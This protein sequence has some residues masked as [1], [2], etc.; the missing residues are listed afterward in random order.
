MSTERNVL[1]ARLPTEVDRAGTYGVSRTTVTRAIAKLQS[2]GP[3][4]SRQGDGT[5]VENTIP[6]A[7]ALFVSAVLAAPPRLR[8]LLEL[9]RL[10]EKEIGRLAVERAGVRRGVRRVSPHP[11]R[12]LR[13]SD[14]VEVYRRAQ[15]LLKQQMLL[16]SRRTGA[17]ER[18]IAAHARTRGL[19]LRSSERGGGGPCALIGG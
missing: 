19:R 4:R 15:D 9:R 14:P 12:G 17:A 2:M 3:I 5:Y 18:A 13:Q 6:R 1:S 8:Q 7:S 16:G 10:L 11:V